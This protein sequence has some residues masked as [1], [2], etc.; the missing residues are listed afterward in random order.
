[1]NGAPVLLRQRVAILSRPVTVGWHCPDACAT[2][3]QLSH[4]STGEGTEDPRGTHVWSLLR[5]SSDVFLHSDSHGPAETPRGIVRLRA[6]VIKKNCVE[7]S[8]T[9]QRPAEL[10]DIRRRFHP[11]GGCGVDGCKFL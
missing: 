7:A 9:K 2:L 11:A 3:P 5:I 6:I 1:M 4:G 10:P 8:I